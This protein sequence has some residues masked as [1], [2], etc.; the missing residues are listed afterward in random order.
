MTYLEVTCRY[1]DNLSAPVL[2]RLADL[3]GYYGIVR[4]HIDEE[5]RQLRV[6]YDASRLRETDVLHMLRLA[7]VD[8]TEK[9]ELT[10]AA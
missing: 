2:R 9:I 1:R 3:R 7:G 8:I 10:P 5:E 4:L 6:E